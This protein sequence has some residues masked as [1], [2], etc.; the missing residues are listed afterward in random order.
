MRDYFVAIVILNVS[1]KHNVDGNYE[2]LNYSCAKPEIAISEYS[3][4]CDN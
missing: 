1:R 2:T 4:G 3:I